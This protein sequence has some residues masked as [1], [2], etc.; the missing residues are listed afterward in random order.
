M[1]VRRSIA[2]AAVLALAG[3]CFERGQRRRVGDDAGGTR[4]ADASPVAADLAAGWLRADPSGAPDDHAIVRIALEAEP[5]P[6]DPF[7]SIDAVSA[8]VLGEVTPGLVCMSDGEPR[9]ARRRRARW[10][11][12]RRR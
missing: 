10:P 9:P 12:R 6:L 4:R 7:A 8:R 5:A 3:G 11:R 1:V 2:I